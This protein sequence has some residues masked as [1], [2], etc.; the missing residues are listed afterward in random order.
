ML[1]QHAT[2]FRRAVI[3]FDLFIILISFF[4]AYYIRNTIEGNKILSI[5]EY[6]WLFPV[7]SFLWILFLYLSGMYNSF[8]F[9]TIS[10]VILIIYQSAY[11]SFLSFAG[12][13]YL[14]K[15]PHIS[16]LFMLLIF[17]VVSLLLTIEKLL[18]IAIFRRLRKKGF[19]YRNI[20][21]VGTGKMARSFVKWIKENREFGL[22]IIGLVD[23]EKERVG[24][25]IE[26][27][28]VI[29]TLEDI[30]E[31]CKN[32]TLDQ[33]LFVV[34]YSWFGQLE[35]PMNY[36]K[37]VGIKMN[38]AM[39]YFSHRL[40]RLIQT[41]FLGVP[42]LT[43]DSTPERRLFAFMIKRVMDIIISATALILLSPIFLIT[44]V[45]IKITSDGPVLFVQERGSLNGRKF[46][47]YKFRT[48][49]VNA[50]KELEQLKAMNEMKGPVFKIENDPRIT[51]IGKILRKFSIDELPQLWNVLKGDMSIVGPRPPLLSEV[52]QYKDWQRRRLSMRPGLTC[53]WQVSGRN[54]ITDFDEWA[55]LDLEYIDN[56]SLWLDIKI[57]LKT[58]PVVIFGI[59]A[60]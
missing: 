54:K 1:K 18:L 45:L 31:I 43:F 49:K 22:N 6:I 44:A 11:L 40:G 29:G 9:K 53:L 26:G 36:L 41:E 47:L 57:M 33:V 23:A 7:L 52:Q 46:K 58:I 13:I 4:I 14:L 34:P 38:I 37:T 21:I 24:E 2:L 30:P 35:E 59:G 15:I 48:M 42:M 5:T 27:Y 12:I 39:H 56:W 3:I 60:K 51:K 10:Q 32:N 19:N 17:L 25:I 20:L 16:R 55:R 8:R 28:P 50:E